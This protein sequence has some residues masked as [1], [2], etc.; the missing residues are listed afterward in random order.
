MRKQAAVAR[1]F[2]PQRLAQGVGIDL[3]QK[4]PGLAEKMLPCRLRK[5]GQARKMDEAVAQIVI[6]AAIH[7][8]P[9]GL[10]PGRAGG[11]F[12]D[13]A[14]VTRFPGLSLNNL[15][16]PELQDLA[17]RPY[18][19]DLSS[20]SL[21]RTCCGA[22]QRS[23]WR[24]PHRGSITTKPP[25][26]RP[27]AAQA[28]P[29]SRIEANKTAELGSVVRLLPIQDALQCIEVPLCRSRA[30]V[31]MAAADIP[32]GLF[33]HRIRELFQ[34]LPGPHCID[35]NLGC[36]LDVIKS[37]IRLGDRL[38]DR[39]DAVVRHEQHRL[40]ADYPCEASALGRIERRAG[41]LVVVGDL[42]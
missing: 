26:A 5:L 21:A 13:P 36:A 8:L 37:I 38:P 27:G 16:S 24:G 11:Y 35:L 31:Q 29:G 2:P 17:P 23:R 28:F 3:D 30:L 39:A 7:A 14:H 33:D 15:G 6:A 32:L 42:A 19:R 40:V 20:S 12:V 25:S 4:Q 22:R 1:G 18:R 10:A 9:F 41:I 34:R